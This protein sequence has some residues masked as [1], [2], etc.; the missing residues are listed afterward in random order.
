MV[1]HRFPKSGRI[2]VIIRT[3]KSE[4]ARFLSETLI[5]HRSFLSPNCEVVTGGGFS[6]ETVAKSSIIIEAI[7]QLAGNHE[8]A[9]TRLILH[10]QDAVETSQY[11]R[12][13]FICRDIDVL[14]LLMY[15]FDKQDLEI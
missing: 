15:N 1:T 2:S 11:K 4:L 5:E 7:L 9:D 6:D 8:E 14:L 12:L 13:I 3:T 10:A